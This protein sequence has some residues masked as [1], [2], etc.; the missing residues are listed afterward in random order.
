MWI[1]QMAIIIFI[2]CI[3]CAVLYWYR[4]WFQMSWY[5]LKYVRRFLIKDFL[6]YKWKKTYFFLVLG[7]F[8]TTTEVCNV[9]VLNSILSVSC[10][11]QPNACSAAAVLWG[12]Y[13]CLIWKRESVSRYTDIQKAYA[14]HIMDFSC[15]ICNILEYIS[16]LGWILHSA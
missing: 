10:T 3:R 16:K 1:C 8:R 4:R 12:F 15:L 6:L 14:P 9:F 5:H 7:V 11:E 13:C 2:K